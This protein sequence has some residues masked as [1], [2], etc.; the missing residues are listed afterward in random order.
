M[1]PVEQGGEPRA[2]AGGGVS[3]KR[4]VMRLPN[5]LRFPGGHLPLGPADRGR[6]LTAG[7]RRA[8]LVM[9]MI[10]SISESMI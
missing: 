10:S 4:G 2:S 5:V 1:S 3:V 8:I 7:R 9:V 6:G